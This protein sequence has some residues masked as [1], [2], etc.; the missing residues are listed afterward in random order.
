MKTEI[1]N[2]HEI[3][4]IELNNEWWAV[5]SDVAKALGYKKPRNAVNRHALK[6]GTYNDGVSATSYVIIQE[7]DIYRLIFGSKLDSAEQ[8]QKWVFNVIKQLRQS[9]GIEGFQVFR[10]LDKEH[11]KEAM[12]KLNRSIK[13]PKPKDFIKANTIANKAVSNLY[14]HS[15]MVN[16]EAMTPEMLADRE[17]V[18]DETV[19]LMTMKEKYGLQFSV[20]EKI[21]NHQNW[22]E[23]A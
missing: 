19:Q 6:R 20:S 18:L 1:W 8:F 2:D 21:Y 13:D 7:P 12:A 4:F 23:I 17:A 11:Q 15:K 5:G 3:R 16:K 10:M 22:S 9:V 14:G